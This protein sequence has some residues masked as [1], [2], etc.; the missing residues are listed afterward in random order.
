MSA[1]LQRRV[2][3]LEQ[4]VR[5]L[6]QAAWKE[7]KLWLMSLPHEEAIVL[8]EQYRQSDPEF[9]RMLDRGTQEQKRQLFEEFDRLYTA[10]VSESEARARSLAIMQGWGASG[11]GR[12]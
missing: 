12:K 4:H 1:S 7:C 9:H 2:G 3:R 8:R 6:R 10:G 11:N 5:A